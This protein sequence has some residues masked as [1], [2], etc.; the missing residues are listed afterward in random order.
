LIE[1]GGEGFDW[2]RVDERLAHAS[3][4]EQVRHQSV[5]DPGVGEVAWRSRLQRW[6][7]GTRPYL[8]Y[9]RSWE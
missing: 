4:L 2:R 1:L 9:P 5:Q 6:R 3:T 8:L 7:K